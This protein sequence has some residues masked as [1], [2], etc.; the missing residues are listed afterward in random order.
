VAAEQT[1]TLD[2]ECRLL[3]LAVLTGDAELQAALTGPSAAPGAVRDA[4]RDR[5]EPPAGPSSG[6]HRVTSGLD[7]TAR[8]D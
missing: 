6:H 5:D 2:D 4:E 7:R 3:L 1:P 8:A